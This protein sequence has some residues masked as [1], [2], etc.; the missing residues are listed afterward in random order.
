MDETASWIGDSSLSVAAHTWSGQT[1]H[2]LPG[3][4]IHRPTTEEVC[5][6]GRPT[7]IFL[8]CRFTDQQRKKYTV[9]AD[10][11]PSSWDVDS[12]TNKGR[13]TQSGQT[14]RHLPGMSIC[15]P[16]KEGVH[17]LGRPTAI[18]LG[19][20]FADKQRKKYTVWADPPPPPW[21]ADSQTNKGRSTQSGQT[22]HHL[23]GMSIHRP[24]TEEVR[25]LG[26]P[27]ATSM[28]CRITDQQRKKYSTNL[29]YDIDSSRLHEC[30][31]GLMVKTSTSKAA[32]QGP[33]L[34]FAVDLLL[35]RVIP[36]T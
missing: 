7:A 18:F 35:G 12:Q 29:K 36:V 30:L 5:D 31:V 3:M 10:P 8:G 22:H 15:R 28:G 27:T 11:P 32:D 9:W 34:A 19:C 2:H 26:R 24:T 25:D 20:R 23:P 6:L 33:M 21:D 1:H 17:S 13:S 16:T 4:S 14:H